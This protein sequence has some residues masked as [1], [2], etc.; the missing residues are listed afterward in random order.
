MNSVQSGVTDTAATKIRFTRAGSAYEH[1]AFAAEQL[2]AQIIDQLGSEPDLVA[3]FIGGPLVRSAR[4]ITQIVRERTSARRLIG[5]TA[6]GVITGSTELENRA[7]VAALAGRLPGVTITPLRNEDLLAVHDAGEAEGRDAATILRERAAPDADLAAT[8]L[9]V[10]PFS[11]PINGM[12]PTLSRAHLSPD[13]GLPDAVLFG[14][15]ASGATAPGGN[16]LILDDHTTN[17]GIVGVSLSGP[18][19]CDMAVSQGCRPIG[20]NLIVTRSKGNLLFELGGRPALDAIRNIVGDL[21]ESDRRLLAGGLFIGRVIDE[22]KDHFGRGDYLIRNVLG[23]EEGSG[24]V[25]VADIIPPGRTVRLHLRDAATAHEDLA[26]LLDA[27]AL[28]GPP[29]GAI[30]ITCNGRGER[31]FG[32]QNHD[33]VAIQRAFLPAEPGPDA[34]KIGRQIDRDGATIPLAGFF[35]AGEIGPVG[36]ES[37]LHGY[38]ACLACF[39][40]PGT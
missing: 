35:A 14:G 10:D 3:L 29:A 40:D 5:V 36:R 24:G 8:F 37:F 39:R 38:T 20:E 1:P 21:D 16:T 33:A 4:I 31:F 6:G 13:P 27:Q 18:V 26:L 22:Y 17:E 7:G 2:A 19:R 28:H 15:V 25:A 9:L 11:V 34:A 12:I 32:R 30:L 23:A